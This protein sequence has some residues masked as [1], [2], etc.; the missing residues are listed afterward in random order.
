MYINRI[1]GNEN[2]YKHTEQPGKIPQAEE[3][4]H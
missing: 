3:V 1:F 4:I 2:N